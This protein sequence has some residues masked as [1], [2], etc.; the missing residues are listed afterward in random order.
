MSETD[1]YRTNG[2]HSAMKHFEI[3]QDTKNP[4]AIIVAQDNKYEPLVQKL[5]HRLALEGCSVET[6]E[7][8]RRR[9]TTQVHYLV[10]LGLPDK[11]EERILRNSQ[12]QRIVIAAEATQLSAVQKKRIRGLPVVFLPKN[13][14]ARLKWTTENI[15]EA[16]FSQPDRKKLEREKKDEPKTTEE[17][18]CANCEMESEISEVSQE[19]PPQ[20][21]IGLTPT[22]NIPHRISLVEKRSH[23]RPLLLGSL[24]IIFLTAVAIGVLYPY[25]IIQQTRTNLQSSLEALQRA[26]FTESKSS[27]FKAQKATAK[28]ASL[29]KISQPVITK[30][31][32]R[33]SRDIAIILAAVNQTTA[34]IN[35][36]A[37]L[38]SRGSAFLSKL[39]NHQPV[40]VQQETAF[41]N[42][43]VKMLQQQLRQLATT[44]ELLA[45]S[46]SW[47]ARET[48]KATKDYQDKLPKTLALLAKTQ[49]IIP[50]LSEI[51]A[52]EDRKKYLVLFQNN[53]ELRPTGG[54]I[55]S[56][57]FLRFEGGK[58]LELNVEDVY[59][60]DG[61]LEGHIEPPTPLKKHLGEANWFLRDAN[62]DPD[63]SRSADQIRWFLKKEIQSDVDGVIAVDLEFAKRALAALNGIT[64]PDTNSLITPDNL[65]L[66]TQTYSEKEF[67]PGSTR[68]RDFLGSLAR[69]MLIEIGTQDT[70]ATV[71][72][73]NAVFSS[74]AEK[75]ILLNFDSD[76]VQQAFDNL[77]WTGRLLQP[78]CQ[79]D[80]STPPLQQTG[81]P[82]AGCIAD[83]LMIIDANLGVNKVNFF[84]ERLTELDV[85]LVK[86]RLRRTLSLS[87]T[88]QGA[89]DKFPSGIYKNYLRILV[90]PNAI[91][92]SVVLNNNS[93]DVSEVDREPLGEYQSL[94]ILFEV[95]PSST[96]TV[97]LT[98]TTPI[99]LPQSA[100]YE[101]LVQKQPGTTNPPFVLSMQTVADAQLEGQNFVP[102]V[103]EGSLL[104]NT[105][106][107]TDK[108]FRVKI[109]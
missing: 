28:I 104:Y 30:A 44:L 97:T 76:R 90:P 94:G 8:V 107:N 59:S 3:E 109:L 42:Q 6:R 77:G 72:L 88:N 34:A 105:T 20:N 45:E 46:P 33:E 87:Y 108:I 62:W 47:L 60:L 35:T 18:G 99:S 70:A 82:P 27:A 41:F 75:H 25:L 52:A 84:V 67:F 31:A 96:R 4:V 89:S 80:P 64:I 15:L 98:H 55:G 9:G 63:F 56:V 40:A 95:P 50:H 103:R 32:P 78:E 19:I 73:T 69:S 102:L 83:F 16:L 92:E 100:I 12:T 61:Q 24:F 65:Y 91:L 85:S 49:P 58:M 14:A 81:Q 10:Y 48:Q 39:F 23:F 7:Y 71:Q 17:T 5:S 36:S 29:Y 68:K 43:R 51:L 79:T 57:G 1:E 13:F 53:M 22:S 2:N 37:E 54:F 93:I 66:A 38:G 101:L 86:R 11:E 26:D 74:L 21:A 106:L